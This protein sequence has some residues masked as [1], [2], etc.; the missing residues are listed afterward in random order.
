MADGRSIDG[1]TTLETVVAFTI[2]ALVLGAASQSIALSAR[3]LARAHHS[4]D[5]AELARELVAHEAAG[6]AGG[7]AAV[8]GETDGD[9]W[10]VERRIVREGGRSFVALR[11]SI[12]NGAAPEAFVTLLPIPAADAR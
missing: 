1:F 2:L 8:D 3:S 9:G 4:V 12:D 6:V 7:R 10:T 5:A 11:V